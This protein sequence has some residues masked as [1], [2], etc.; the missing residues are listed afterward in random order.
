MVHLEPFTN[1]VAGLANEIN[2]KKRGGILEPLDSWAIAGAVGQQTRDDKT[3]YAL[4]RSRKRQKHAR[5]RHG[6]EPV[7]PHQRIGAIPI[8]RRG[9]LGLA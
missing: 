6:E 3:G 2:D 5:V 9:C 8:F 4:F 1:A 7:V